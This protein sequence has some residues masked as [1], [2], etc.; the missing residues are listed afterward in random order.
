MSDGSLLTRACVANSD[1]ATGDALTG[2]DAGELVRKLDR[3]LRALFGGL[4]AAWKTEIALVCA[5]GARYAYGF[6]VWAAPDTHMA[7]TYG[8]PQIRIWLSR[9]GR[10]RYAYGFHV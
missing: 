3:F 10:P 1:L 4:K 6:H 2:I 9:M 7:F 8:P 5:R